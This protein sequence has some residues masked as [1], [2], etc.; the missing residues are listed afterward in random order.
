MRNGSNDK[1]AIT[2][3]KGEECVAQWLKQNG[4][5][6]L[7]RNYRVR[8]GEVDL[9]A[10][11]NEVIA[12]VEVK[13]RTAH[14][15]SLSEVVTKKKQEKIARAAR[16]FIAEHAN[17]LLSYRFDVALIEGENAVVYIENAFSVEQY[18]W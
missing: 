11:K 1:R 18:A 15:F 14:Y 16:F 3:K 6:I 13:C 8:S 9:I 17:L 10:Q 2:G 12:F 4:Y 5:V 7:A